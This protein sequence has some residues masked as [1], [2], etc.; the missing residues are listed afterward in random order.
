MSQ[1]NGFRFGA[2]ALLIVI[3]GAGVLLWPLPSLGA[4]FN[5]HTGRVDA[6]QPGSAAERAGLHV[7]DRITRI[8]GYPWVE[9]NT[10]VL[11]LP[12]PWR[13]GTPTP[14]TITRDGASQELVLRTDSPAPELQVEKL[15]RSLIALVCWGTGAMLGTSPRASDRRL[16][17]TG[18]FWVLLGGTLGL[19]PLTQLTSYVLTIGVLW[20]QC[21]VL[22]PVAVAVQC[23]Y[24]PRPTSSALQ[25]RTRW[26]LVG[27]IAIAQ[28]IALRVV[29]AGPVTSVLYEQ[30]LDAVRV[31]FLVSFGLSAMLLFRAYLTTTIAHIRRQVRL[32]GAACILAGAWTA[33]LLLLHWVSP[34]LGN[35]VPPAA[36]P[37]GATFIPLAYLTGGVRADLMQL[38]QV[39]RRVVLHTLTLLSAVTLLVV[40]GYLELFVLTPALFVV[41]VLLLY[42]PIYQ[43]MQRL[44]TTWSAAIRREQALREAAQRLGTSLETAYLIDILRDGIRAAFLTPPLVIY[45]RAD[46]NGIMRARG[47][48]HEVGLPATMPAFLVDRLSAHGTLLVK[49][50]ELQQV[51]EHEQADA[52]IAGLVFHPSVALWGLIRDQQEQLLGLVLLGPR[53]DDDPYQAHD[54]RELEQLLRTAALAFTNSASYAAQVEARTE[55]RALR[56]HAEQIEE[57]TAAEIAGEIH[58]QVLST[59]LR[60]NMEQL[61]TLMRDVTDPQLQERLADV[62]AAEETIGDTLRFVCEQLK[63][64]GHDDPLGLAASLRQEA[65]WIRAS[66]RV[67]ALVQPERNP[68]PLTRQ[69]QR[70]LVKITHEAL[71]NAVAHGKPTAL[72][73]RVRFPTDESEPLVLTIANDGPRPPEPIAPKRNHWG[74]RTMHEYADAVGAT[75]RWDRP[76]TGGTCVVVTVPPDVIGRVV[77]EA[78]KPAL[79]GLTDD[80]GEREIPDGISVPQ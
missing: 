78:Q 45:H 19:Y 68:V 41:V 18:W 13:Q 55:I 57:Q 25:R 33:I 79:D 6:V 10:R 29:L 42:A 38:E 46:P 76:D 50:V 53:G 61:A 37:L 44:G 62:L 51:L 67:P 27:T 58:D 63:P 49:A 72:M 69:M 54:L 74:V 30:L 75:I 31:T 15:I 3:L 52:S 71:N 66:W 2:L 32:I 16:R 60:L 43:A 14:V 59:Q 35:L 80:L 47:V 48:P 64:T 56:A 12:L 36:F 73:V 65:Q 11:L 22:A 77:R 7:G 5:L 23:W 4:D 21:S 1:N 8:Y 20:F 40:S 39:V 24:P 34:P 17:W 28:L 70:A 26:L 9:V